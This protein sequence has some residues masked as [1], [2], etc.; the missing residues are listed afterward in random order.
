MSWYNLPPIKFEAHNGIKN[1]KNG[2]CPN[3]GAQV[4]SVKL[5]CE[6]CGTRFSE[7]MIPIIVERPEV[8]ILQ[9]NQKVD[10]EA[11]LQFGKD[12]SFMEYIKMDVAKRMAMELLP[13][14]D[15]VTE[16]DPLML[17]KIIRARLRVVDK[18]FHF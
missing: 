4:N 12:P 1:A 2:V 9:T 17:Q 3:C 14:I 18:E 10:M 11:I 7:D 16:D 13:Y 15:F 5:L 8:K 6:Y